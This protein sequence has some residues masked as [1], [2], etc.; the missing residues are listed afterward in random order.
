MTHKLMHMEPMTTR[1]AAKVLGVH[2]TTVTRMVQ[3]GVMAAIRKLEGPTGDLL[4]D[5]A[6][7]DRVATE[8]RAS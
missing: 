1:E 3:R 7:V 4:F 2:H 5:P 6:E 8:R